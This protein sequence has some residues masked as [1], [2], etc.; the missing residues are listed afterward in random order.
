MASKRL[1]RRKSCTGKN[2]FETKLAAI[3]AKTS[4]KYDKEEV[5]LGVYKCKFAEHWHVGHK[6]RR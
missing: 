5:R 4:L 1:L 2:R 6:K 3:H